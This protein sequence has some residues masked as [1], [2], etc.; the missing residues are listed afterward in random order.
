MKYIKAMLMMLLLVVLVSCTTTDEVTY[1]ILINETTPTT[2]EVGDTI[3]YTDFFIIKDSL[4]NTV[5]TQEAMLDVSLVDMSKAGSY[6][7][8]I[9]YEG[10]ENQVTITVTATEEEITYTLSINASLPTTLELNTT[11]VDFKAYFTITDSNGNAVEVLE[12]MI[13]S[14]NVNLGEVGTYNLVL[15]YQ[16]LSKTVVLEVVDRTPVIIYS[17]VINDA[18]PTEF[19]VGTETVDFKAYFIITDSNE[20]TIEVTD[21]MLDLS[22]VDFTKIGT[23]SITLNLYAI[24][25]VL[26]FEVTP[27]YS[28]EDEVIEDFDILFDLIK[29]LELNSKGTATS[30]YSI[31]IKGTVYMDVQNE[32][33]LVYIT[34]GKNFIKLHGEKVHNYTSLNTVYEVK[35][36]F[37]SHLYIPTFSV[38]NP[39]TDIKVI[40]GATPVSTITVKEVSLSTIL[41]LKLENFVENINNGYLQ[42]MLKVTGYLQL[43]TH[44]STRWDY[45]LTATETYTKNNTQYINN[46]LYFK[47]DI[48]ELEDTLID[49]E[50][51]LE[52]ENVEVSVF[53]VIYDWNPNRKNWR[54][55]VSN[56]LTA[57]FLQ[58]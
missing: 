44:N 56:T 19:K 24:E 20:S 25:H 23:F 7:I 58:A 41:N 17:V 54:L 22:L 34:D 16:G 55:Y 47:N 49:Y 52:Y 35:G 53:G 8:R 27:D 4:G 40:S 30:A 57:D 11:E 9:S 2:Y 13:D 42:S 38:V 31:T 3:T 29:G 26:S 45:A 39:G 51:D 48:G 14:S 12:S 50:V 6:M 36:K 1:E 15:N 33:T 43:D 32:T 37:K 5:T 18:L 21:D 10:V 28:Y 46:G